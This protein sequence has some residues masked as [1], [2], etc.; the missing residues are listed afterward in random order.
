MNHKWINNVCTRCGIKRTK[1]RHKQVLFL[2]PVLTPT[3]EMYDKPA[4]KVVQM[5]HYSN[6]HRFKRPDC[7]DE[8]WNK[9]KAA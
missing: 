8:L 4:T 5:Y 7:P 9:K 3:G 1:R 6:G 2:Y